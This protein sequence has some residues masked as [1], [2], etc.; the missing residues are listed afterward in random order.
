MIVSGENWARSI[1]SRTIGY[2]TMSSV[3]RAVALA[4]L[5]T[6][7]ILMPTVLPNPGEGPPSLAHSLT[8]GGFADSIRVTFDQAR[9]ANASAAVDRDGNIHVVWEDFRSGNGDI[10]YA[11]LDPY[12]NKLTNDAKI[13]ND[14]SPSRHPVVAVDADSHIYIV[15]E[16]L[17]GTGSELYYAKLWYYEGNITFLANG[18][19]VSDSDPADSSEPAIAVDGAGYLSIVWSDL[20][21]GNREIYY[22]LLSPTGSALTSDVRITHD[23]GVSS[24]PRIAMDSSGDLHVVWYDFRDSASGQVINHGVFYRKL[25]RVGAPLT[26]ERRITFASPDSHPDLA[27]DGEGNVHVVF[28][29]D[30]Y[31]NFD[32]FYT[33]LDNTGVTLLDDRNVSAKDAYESRAPRI[34]LVSDGCLDI[35]WQDNSSGKWRIMCASYAASGERSSGPVLISS[36]GLSAAYSPVVLRGRD[37]NT[38]VLFTGLG[39]NQEIYY[40]RTSLPDLAVSAPGIVLSKAWPVEDTVVWANLTV[41]NLGGNMTSGFE[42]ELLVDEERVASVSLPALASRGSKA[43]SFAFVPDIFAAEVKVRLDPG[44]KIRETDEG[45]NEARTGITVRIPRVLAS[46]N[47]ASLSVPPGTNASFNVTVTNTGSSTFAFALKI[48]GLE[49][50]WTASVTNVP[51]GMIFIPAGSDAVASVLVAVPSNATPGARR[52]DVIVYCIEKPDVNSTATVFVDV[53]RVGDLRLSV[54]AGGTVTPTEP[55]V[56]ELLLAN[57]ANAPE[58]FTCRAQDVRG[59]SIELSEEHARLQPG[60]Q[61]VIELYVLADRYEPPG[62]I[63][64]IT[65]WFNSTDLTNNRA[66]ANITLVV[67][68]HRELALEVTSFA[69][70]NLT[71]PEEWQARYSLAVSN[72]GNVRD[73]VWLNQ[74]GLPFT[75]LFENSYLV[76]DPGET[77]KV[78][79]TVLLSPSA[80]AGRYDFCVRAESGSDSTANA[81]LQMGVTVLPYHDIKVSA[82]RVDVL[83]RPGRTE[84]VNITLTNA[85]NVLDQVELYVFTGSFRSAILTVNGTDYVLATDAVPPLSLNPGQ[86][87]LITLTIIVPKNQSAGLEQ[88]YADFSSASDPLVSTTLNITVQ[89]I[90][91]KPWYKDIKLLAM[92]GGAGATAVVGSLILVRARAA[93]EAERAAEEQKAKAKP[94]GQGPRTAR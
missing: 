67:G 2:S 28:D 24:R 77:E 46:A 89:V 69:Y 38:L 86:S 64:T 43:L 58:N 6:A 70:L 72:L 71:A 49:H 10:Y 16:D 44:G 54:P 40:T 9:S 33:M 34:A 56:Y 20:R 39:D 45:N 4:L 66:S 62:T 41:S 48:M 17:Q 68:T 91:E 61:H 83:T 53:Q 76:L 73:V 7:V 15:W 29:D 26:I 14:S 21:D 18:V 32:I 79:L 22:K 65:L 55:V 82:D 50:G 27:I 85:G 11:K 1:M 35:V 88:L 47:V 36:A 93:A 23:D 42:V 81:T 12:G 52:V 5:T 51:L 8:V 84:R 59:W 19:R 30:R 25:D 90:R 13:T 31:A 75:A 94:K 92:I 57:T 78:L 63:N 37:N 87:A 60:V 74:T 3:S 80:P